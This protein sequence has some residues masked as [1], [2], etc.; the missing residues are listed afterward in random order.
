MVA[1]N[2]FTDPSWKFPKVD[3]K[4]D[5]STFVRR[6]NLLALAEKNKAQFDVQKMMQVLDT[7][8]PNGGATVPGSAY[9]IIAV[10]KDL[11]LWIKAQNHFGWQK[12][13]I[14]KLLKNS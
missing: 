7:R 5:A 1:T 3:D 13:N 2:H 10:P 11:T 12:A 6:D 4:T 8:V 14:S 9:Q